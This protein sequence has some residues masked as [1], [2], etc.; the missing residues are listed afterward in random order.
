MCK[1]DF[2]V[3]AFEVDFISMKQESHLAC[4][5]E[6]VAHLEQ[7]TLSQN[8]RY[9]SADVEEHGKPVWIAYFE[10]MTKLAASTFGQRLILSSADVIMIEDEFRN[11]VLPDHLSQLFQQA[12]LLDMYFSIYFRAFQTGIIY[13]V[14]IRL[15]DVH[16]GDACEALNSLENQALIWVNQN[17][18]TVPAFTPSTPVFYFEFQIFEA[19]EPNSPCKWTICSFENLYTRN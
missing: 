11:F 12:V 14:L 6:G 4:S 1:K 2:I 16:R 18:L 19:V 15:K 7:S 17:N 10:I 13:I 9:N 3:D 5:P 8:T